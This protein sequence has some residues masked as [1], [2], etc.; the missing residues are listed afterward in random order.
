MST[1]APSRGLSLWVVYDHPRDFPDHYVA[2]RWVNGRAQLSPDDV[3]KCGNLQ[4]VRVAM[5][6]KGLTRIDRDP[7]DDPKILEV[8]L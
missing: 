6:A 3:V 7:S 8:W 2:R 5:E 1:I 4:L